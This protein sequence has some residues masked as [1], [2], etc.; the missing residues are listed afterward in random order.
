MRALYGPKVWA[1]PILYLI[2]LLGTWLLANESG[3]LW[4][5]FGTR[6]LRNAGGGAEAPT[7]LDIRVS[8]RCYCS[9][10]RKPQP[11]VL[12][13]WSYHRDAACACS[14]FSLRRS[15]K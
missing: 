6:C 5:R 4:G 1:G 11:L 13:V 12:L 3:R 2:A 14:G 10:A 9:D 7:K 15:A 8:I